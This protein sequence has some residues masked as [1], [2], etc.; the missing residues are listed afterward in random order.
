MTGTGRNQY[1][2]AGYSGCTII[3]VSKISICGRNLRRSWGDGGNCKKAKA[4]NNKGR[5]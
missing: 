3:E 1:G 2:I 5:P 4:K